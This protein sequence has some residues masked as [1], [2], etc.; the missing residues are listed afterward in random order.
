[1]ICVQT[2]L[3]QDKNRVL[4]VWCLTSKSLYWSK[5]L[6]GVYI[7]SSPVCPTSTKSLKTD[8]MSEDKEHLNFKGLYLN[9]VVFQYLPCFYLAMASHLLPRHHNN[10]DTPLHLPIGSGW[11]IDLIN[12]INEPKQTSTRVFQK[13]L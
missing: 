5:H 10:I 3:P 7:G 1:M 2:F 12:Q 11:V 6:S 4:V 8:V 9:R 13:I